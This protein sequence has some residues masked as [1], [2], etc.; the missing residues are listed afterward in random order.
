MALTTTLSVFSRDALFALF[1]YILPF[2]CA[3]AYKSSHLSSICSSVQWNKARMK[4]NFCI[5]VQM[6]AM[7]VTTYSLSTSFFVK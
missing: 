4:E 7:K 5:E 6:I 1:V 2:M 3:D